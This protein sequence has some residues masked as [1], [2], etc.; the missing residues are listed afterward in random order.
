MRFGGKLRDKVVSHFFVHHDALG[1]H[2]DLPLIDEGAERGGVH[3]LVEIG[4]VKH[5][6]RRLAAKLEQN[7]L[8]M[9]AGRL[10]NDA[11]DAGRA[12]EIDPTHRRVSD[13]RLDDLTG[14]GRCIADDIDDATRESGIGEH[15]A[16]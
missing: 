6:Q 2:A 3:R 1:R 13:Q 8:E 9:A 12:R 10:G 11:P 5:Q 15:L 4:V 16:Q 14:V 7:G